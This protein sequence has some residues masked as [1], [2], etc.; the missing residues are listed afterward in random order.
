MASAPGRRPA[1]P[2]SPADPLPARIACHPIEGPL[3]SVRQNHSRSKWSNMTTD[4][5]GPRTIAVRDVHPRTMRTLAIGLL[6]GCSLGI[7]A[8]AWMRLIA[9]EPA[10]TWGGTIFIVLGFTIF[11]FTQAIVA[12]ATRRRG[13]G[14]IL[15]IARLLGT[16]GLMPLF[17]GA[18]AVDAPDRGR[19]WLHVCPPRMATRDSRNLRCRGVGPG[20][21]RRARLGR[22]VRLVAAHCCRVR[23]DARRVRHDRQCGAVHIRGA[24]DG[25]RLPRWTR[26]AGFVVLGLVFAFFMAGTIFR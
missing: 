21:V 26:V 1:C 4:L 14:W 8:R 7:V 17:V 24:P 20:V 19:R 16:V 11:G 23:S 25:W 15:T 6:G 10:F 3:T 9:E 12:I 5:A 22:F 2:S 13:R 18:G